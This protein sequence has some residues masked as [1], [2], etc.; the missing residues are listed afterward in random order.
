ME[1]LKL[2]KAFREIKKKNKVCLIDLDY[3]KK[4][5]TKLFSMKNFKDFNEFNQLKEEYMSENG[6]IIVPSFNVDDPR[7]FL[8]LKN[9]NLRFL[10]FMLNLTM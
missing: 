5:L 9:L 2:S 1:K 4:G 8:C 10:N 3:R 6:S 7:I